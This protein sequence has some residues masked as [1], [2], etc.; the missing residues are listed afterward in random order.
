MKKIIKIILCIVLVFSLCACK[1][2]ND[3]KVNTEIHSSFLL[4]ET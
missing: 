3:V 1:K 4:T 2:T